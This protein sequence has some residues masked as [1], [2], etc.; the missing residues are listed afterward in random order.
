M[1]KPAERAAAAPSQ[2]VAE[3]ERSGGT[4][5]QVAAFFDSLP[6]VTV[7]AMVGSWKGAGITTGHPLEG[8][9]ERYGWY[10]KRFESAEVVHPLV[11]GRPG[12]SYYL[13]PA[14]LSLGF[15]RRHPAL[16]RAPLVAGIARRGFRL[17]ATRAPTAR[18]RMTTFRGVSS[19]TMLY[20]AH[21]IADVFRKVDDDTVLG[22][23]DIRGDAMPDLFYFT[24]RRDDR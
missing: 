24:L 17:F 11:M 12:S 10:G 19:A 3:L 7:E 22:A 21:P 2:V 5:A 6:A 15:A 18:L 9:L 13:D 1:S 14:F 20:D 23:M 16:V 4:P 8:L